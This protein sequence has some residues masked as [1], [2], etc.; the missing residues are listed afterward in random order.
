MIDL[1]INNKVDIMGQKLSPTDNELYKRI[2]EVLHYIWDPIGV[3]G[4]AEARDEYQTYIPQI[5]QLT[6]MEHPE[7]KIAAHLNMIQTEQMGL[8]P[9]QGH[10]KEV[11]EV[12][13]N[14]KEVL[15]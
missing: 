6:K 11:A 15:N 3:S 1:I 12:I 9:N 10:C 2:D 8:S 13:M 14:W 7:E 4:V 5:F